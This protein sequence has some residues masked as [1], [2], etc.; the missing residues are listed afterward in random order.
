M[1]RRRILCLAIACF[2]AGP[3]RA[4][5]KVHRIGYLSARTSRSEVAEARALVIRT[6]L[7]VA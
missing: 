7:A 6:G 1:N 3:A 4:Q 2:A 5:G